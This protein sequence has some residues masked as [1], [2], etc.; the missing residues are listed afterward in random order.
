MHNDLMD[1]IKL[2]IV[3]VYQI[4]KLNIRKDF[5]TRIRLH[6]SDFEQIA[7]HS[8]INDNDFGTLIHK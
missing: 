2:I 3:F 6:Y 7:V 1:M 5:I 8:M 4:L